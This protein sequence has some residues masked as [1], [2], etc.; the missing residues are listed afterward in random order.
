MLGISSHDWYDTM[1]SLFL[2]Y[3]FILAALGLSYSSQELCCGR[4]D[5]VP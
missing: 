1:N 3:V 2:K 4:W 5:L